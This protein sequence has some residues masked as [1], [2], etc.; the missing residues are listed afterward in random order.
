VAETDPRASAPADIAS[1]R[2][3][4]RVLLP[5]VGAAL[6][7]DLEEASRQLGASIPADLLED[8]QV[9]KLARSRL[10][11]DSAYPPWSP[12]AVILADRNAMIGHIGFHTAPD[13]E[14]L[15]PFARGAVEVGYTVFEAYRRQGYAR[16]ALEAIMAWASREHGIRNFIASVSPDN[17]ASLAVLRPLFFAKVGAHVDDEDGPEDIFLRSLEPP[18]VRS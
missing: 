12:R 17:L 18:G 1:P 6:S 8:P 5:A 16:E 3:I 9:L 14:Y 10:E 2:L 11:A 7:G 13:P 4:L 15:H